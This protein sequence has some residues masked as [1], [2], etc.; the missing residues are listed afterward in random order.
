MKHIYIALFLFSYYGVI[1]SHTLDIH[2]PSSEEKKMEDDRQ[3]DKEN[4]EAHEVIDD[5][6]SSDQDRIDAFNTL[7]DNGEMA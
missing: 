6:D 3:K 4:E 5:P 2:F 1:E 7:I